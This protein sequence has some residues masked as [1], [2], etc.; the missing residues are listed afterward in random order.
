MPNTYLKPEERVNLV[1][2]A[3]QRVGNLTN[4]ITPFNGDNFVGALND[5][6]VYTTKGITKARDYEFRTRTRPIVFDEI[7][8]TKLP[9]SIDQHMTVGNRWTDEEEK[10]DRNSFAREIALPMAEAMRDRFDVKVLA[11]LQAADWAVTSLDFTAA[12]LA[13]DNGAL[14]VGLRLKSQLDAVGTPANGRYLVLGANAFLALASSPGVL[15]YDPSQANTVFRRG[16]FGTVAGFE[17]VDGTLFMGENDVVAV[18]R[19]WAVL[20]NAAP[21]NPQGAVWSAN[22]SAFGYAA[23]MLLDYDV[24]YAS[25]RA[26]LNSFWGISEINDQYARHTQQTANAANDGSEKGDVIIEDGKPKTTGK[27]VRGGKGTFTP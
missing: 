10:F 18:H 3:L 7:Y 27:N 20:A 19:S 24:D 9:I 6:L 13:A 25:D 15:K 5:T 4:L 2:A 21:E 17:I 8:R 16:V 26:L 11:R 12:E 1:L 14:K 22:A 23:R